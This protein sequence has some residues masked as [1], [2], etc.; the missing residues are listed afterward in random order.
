[1]NGRRN[2]FD[3]ES[4]KIYGYYKEF[5]NSVDVHYTDRVHRDKGDGV[6]RTHYPQGIRC[7]GVLKTDVARG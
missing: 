2:L 5:N 1:M 3:R 4:M 6:N 7:R